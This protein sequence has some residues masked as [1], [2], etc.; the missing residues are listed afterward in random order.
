MENKIREMDWNIKSEPI[1]IGLIVTG[2]CVKEDFIITSKEMLQIAE[3]K[4]DKFRLRESVLFSAYDNHGE[5]TSKS[6]REGKGIELNSIL[7]E[8]IIE[9]PEEIKFKSIDNFET[10]ITEYTSEKH[11]YFPKIMEGNSEIYEEVSAL[12]AFYSDKSKVKYFPY[13]NLMIGQKGMEDKN[14]DFFAKGIK[15]IIIG[16]RQNILSVQGKAVKRK[17][18]FTLLNLLELM[19]SN[20]LKMEEGILT[21]KNS[22]SDEI[23]RVYCRGISLSILLNYVGINKEDADIENLKIKFDDSDKNIYVKDILEPSNK[24]FCVLIIEKKEKKKA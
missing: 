4:S 20:Y 23:H 15:A 16:N 3:G 5:K 22:D 7:K 11:Y 14:K 2:S 12:L 21:Y 6:I 24:F 18:N 1:E 17:F 8:A 19:D 10:T 13:P 9:N